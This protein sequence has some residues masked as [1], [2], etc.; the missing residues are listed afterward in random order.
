MGWKL[1]ELSVSIT[2]Q[3][4]PEV[5]LNPLGA[6]RG[7]L[8]STEDTPLAVLLCLGCV[9]SG[10]RYF[11]FRLVHYHCDFHRTER[12]YVLSYSSIFLFA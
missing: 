5:L 9:V 3:W 2:Y 12:F 10:I 11:L 8:R 1:R 7:I 4:L 6:S